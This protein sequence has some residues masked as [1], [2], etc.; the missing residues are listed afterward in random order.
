MQR[1]SHVARPRGV[2]TW[3]LREVTEK[4]V[5][6]SYNIHSLMRFEERIERLLSEI[7]G[8]SWDLFMLQETW[9]RKSH[10]YTP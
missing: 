4:F 6:I 2:K 9:R 5:V 8:H 1:K 3:Q 10:P 7:E